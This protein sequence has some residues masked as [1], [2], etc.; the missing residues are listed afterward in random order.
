MQQRPHISN[1]PESLNQCPPSVTDKLRRSP[2]VLDPL[3]LKADPK[4]TLN[5]EGHKTTET[6]KVP[7]MSF[8]LAA[9]VEI[10]D[11]QPK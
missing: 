7:G 5:L 1:K 4:Y 9:R 3:G 8:A 10:G 6:R 11:A 2:L